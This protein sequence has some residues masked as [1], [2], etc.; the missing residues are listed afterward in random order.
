MNAVHVG[1]HYGNLVTYMRM[2]RDGPPSSQ[3]Q[4]Q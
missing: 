1:E 3:L 2:K 4:G